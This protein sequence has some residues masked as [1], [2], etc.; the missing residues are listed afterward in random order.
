MKENIKYLAR[1]TAMVTGTWLKINLFFGSISVI[2]IFLGLF[3]LLKDIDSGHSGHT[4]AA[5]A[6]VLMFIQKPVG[7]ILW[8]LMLACIYLV[9]LF[10]GKYIIAKLINRIVQDKSETII[11]PLLDKIISR[12]K[13]LQPGAV[14]KGIDAAVV[15]MQLSEQLKSEGG[16]KWINRIIHFALKRIA[17]NDVDFTDPELKLDAVI[18]DRIIQFLKDT[19]TPDKT[20]LWLIL[21]F[22]CLALLFIYFFPY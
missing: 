1:L 19:S 9:F 4:S 2:S 20:S 13:A 5:P 21:G 17:L 14:R 11:I 15:R 7:S 12:A 3:F 22:Q 6:L 18:K 8:L 16:Y 10:S